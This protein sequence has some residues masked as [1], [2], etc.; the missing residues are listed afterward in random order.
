ML[1]SSF[2]SLPAKI[3]RRFQHLLNILTKHY[4]LFSVSP[5]PFSTIYKVYITYDTICGTASIA[6]LV[7][8]S[9]ERCMSVTCPAIHRNISQLTIFLC[10]AST[11]LYALLVALL[12][13]I[14]GSYRWYPLFVSNASFFVP[15]MIIIMTYSVIFKIARY[16]A[17]R[18]GSI[19]R[20]VRIAVTLAAVILAFVVAWLPFFVALLIA[21][22][23][24]H[25]WVPP[26]VVSIVKWMQYS[27]S[28]VNPIIYTYRNLEFRATF[29]KILLPSRRRSNYPKRLL[30]NSRN[31]NS[32]AAYNQNKNLPNSKMHMI[33][34]KI[35]FEC[36]I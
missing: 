1:K 13:Y 6:N 4:L 16:R 9:L 28:M 14:E 22:Y 36:S 27:G 32:C 31:S 11:W 20:E 24:R 15:L 7:M 34:E 2:A 12:D 8:I 10:V 35:L 29:I 19:A 26:A 30:Q 21:V 25:C 5:D 33:P 17:R 3:K 23:C 18:I